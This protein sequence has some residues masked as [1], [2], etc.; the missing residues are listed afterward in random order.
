MGNAQSNT[1]ATE[2][3]IANPSPIKGSGNVYYFNGL[4][5]TPWYP[6]SEMI[7]W[8]SSI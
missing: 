6:F 2:M 4:Q 5:E 3:T 8:L 7:P 1:A